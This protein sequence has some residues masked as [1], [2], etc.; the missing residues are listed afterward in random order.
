MWRKYFSLIKHATRVLG[1]VILLIDIPWA[2]FL[3]VFVE[4][5]GMIEDY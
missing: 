4:L 2:I 3:L 5:L 1:L